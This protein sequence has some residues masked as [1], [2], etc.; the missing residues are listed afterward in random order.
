M[1]DR[2]HTRTWISHSYMHTTYKKRAYA[3]MCIYL[4]CNAKPTVFNQY[5]KMQYDCQLSTHTHTSYTLFMIVIV[6]IVIKYTVVV[7]LVMVIIIIIIIFFY[8]LLLLL[9]S[10][11]GLATCTRTGIGTGTCTCTSDGDGNNN[12]NNNN[13]NYGKNSSG[14]C[15]GN[16]QCQSSRKGSCYQNKDIQD[17]ECQNCSY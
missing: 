7:V 14:C 12:N 16:I 1:K 15:F 11:T 3:F 10:S 4:Y 5:S 17:K 13:N 6:V 8:L 9:L 2:T